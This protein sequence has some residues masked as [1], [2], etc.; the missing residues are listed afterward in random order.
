MA[1]IIGT[2]GHDNLHG[3]AGNDSIMGLAGNDTIRGGMGVD[4]M[5]GGI[6]NDVYYADSTHDVVI[7]GVGAGIDTVFASSSY[8]L[9]V[10]EVENL[11]LRGNA[12][13]GYGNELNNHI[14]GNAGDNTLSG[15][16]GNDSIYGLA[17]NDTIYGGMGIDLLVGGVGNDVYYL[18]GD[19]ISEEAGAGIDTVFA[20]TGEILRPNVE[21][22]YLQGSAIYGLGNELNNYIVGNA[23]D[24][25]LSGGTGIDTVIGGLGNDSIT[26]SGIG[27]DVLTGGAGADYFRFHSASAGS[28]TITDFSKAEGDKI[29]LLAFEFYGLNFPVIENTSEALLCSQF[30]TGAGATNSDHRIIYNSSSGAL[31]YDFD[32]TGATAQVQIA[33]LSTGLALTSSD[34]QVV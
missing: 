9:D 12:I 22:L 31:F 20:Y 30:V 5:D 33:S 23:N 34:F 10:N 32:G 6:G 15:D 18:D 28:V 27:S 19:V 14:V 3:T 25:W 1:T 17:G 7:E 26:I 2:S 16:A 4:T 8:A 13:Y 24:N 11:Y 29:E 21:N